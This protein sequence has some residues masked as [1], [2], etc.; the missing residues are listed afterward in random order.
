MVGEGPVVGQLQAPVG[1]A[2][3]AA[4][5]VADVPVA[6]P[7]EQEAQ[8]VAGGQAPRHAPVE[9]GERVAG[10]TGAR[11][12]PSSSAPRR[13]GCGRGRRRARS[14]E[15]ST[16]ATPASSARR[17]GAVAAAGGSGSI[18]GPATAPARPT[19]SACSRSSVGPCS[20]RWRSPSTWTRHWRPIPSRRWPVTTAT[21]WSSR[22][23]RAARSRA[24]CTGW[25][26]IGV[27]KPQTGSRP[28]S[29]RVPVLPRR[30]P[31]ARR[32]TGRRSPP[33]VARAPGTTRR[34]RRTRCSTR[35]TRRR[36]ECG[37]RRRPTHGRC[38]R[39]GRP[40]CAQR[41]QRHAPTGCTVRQRATGLR[42]AVL[43]TPDGRVPPHRQWGGRRRSNRPGTSQATGP[44]GRGTSGE[45][46]AGSPK[47]QAAGRR[48]S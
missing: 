40:R 2:P 8:L 36:R 13:R 4:E 15:Q 30:P 47:E 19:R 26:T 24:A 21:S 46:P 5:D 34:R 18:G 23:R 22:P 29:S 44:P 31:H 3:D 16:T 6:L 45:Q 7:G 25:P 35:R 12:A 20:S 39:A 42:W 43:T 37:R 38:G 17:S 28:S 10:Q 33:R 1:A 48:R 27:A 14:A 41:I 32:R 11:L 9:P